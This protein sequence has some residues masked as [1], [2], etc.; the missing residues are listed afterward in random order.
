VEEA[1]LAAKLDA[2]RHPL[3]PAEFSLDE[4][5]SRLTGE[6][7]IELD[8]EVIFENLAGEVRIFADAINLREAIRNLID[9]A[10]KFSKPPQPVRVCLARSEMPGWIEIRVQDH[11]VGIEEK[12]KPTLFRRFNRIRD[13]RTQGIPGTGLGLHIAQG[14]AQMHAGSILVESGPGEGSTFTIRLPV[15]RRSA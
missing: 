11:G 13:E 3:H 8:R 10:V 14:I 4:F 5:V 6:A 7:Q 2:G 1:V 15:D 12:D 9:N